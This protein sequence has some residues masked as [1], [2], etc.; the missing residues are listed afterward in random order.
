[1]ET[2]NFP[3]TLQEAI[4]FFSNKDNAFNFLVNYRWPKGVTCPRCG[5]GRVGFIAT[6]KTWECKSCKV[7]KQ[8]S[9]KV[10]QMVFRDLAGYEREERYQ[11]VRGC[12]RFG[13]H[14][15]IRLVHAPAH[16]PCAPERNHRQ[17][18]WHS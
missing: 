7:K 4:T 3:E 1:M 2:E 12:P 6:R 9:A 18:R 14:A 17:T 8:F 16:P 15:K 10:E 5:S 13:S 11:F